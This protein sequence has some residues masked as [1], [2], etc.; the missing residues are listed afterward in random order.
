MQHQ[1]KGEDTKMLEGKLF[2]NKMVEL[3][4]D[5]G[6]KH[7][8]HVCSND[9]SRPFVVP[10]NIAQASKTTK[11]QGKVDTC[12]KPFGCGKCGASFTEGSGLRTHMRTHVSEKTTCNVCAATFTCASDMKQHRKI[13]TS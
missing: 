5:S 12:E 4:G 9:V 10:L 2:K 8:I 13:H 3:C 7:S 6:D 11:N 1:H